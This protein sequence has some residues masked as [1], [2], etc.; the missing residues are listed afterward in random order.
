MNLPSNMQCIGSPRNSLQA[1]R[2]VR[3]IPIW[4]IAYLPSNIQCIGSPRHCL[5]AVRVVRM[6]EICKIAYLP[7]NIQCIGSPR[8]CLHAV[9]ADRKDNKSTVYSLCRRFW[10]IKNVC[11]KFLNSTCCRLTF[12]DNHLSFSL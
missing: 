12:F 4:K 6:I 10:N 2:V 9:S 1:V 8:Y 5:Q 7:S 11:L 3:M